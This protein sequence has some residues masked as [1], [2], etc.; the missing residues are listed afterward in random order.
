MAAAGARVRTQVVH[1]C[2]LPVATLIPELGDFEQLCGLCVKVAECDAVERGV[3]PRPPRA[4]AHRALPRSLTRPRP[5]APAGCRC[6]PRKTRGRARVTR[7]YARR[8]PDG[9]G[10]R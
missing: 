8:P 9:R 7:R 1:H 4:L 10:G 6:A 5:S 3:R 2:L